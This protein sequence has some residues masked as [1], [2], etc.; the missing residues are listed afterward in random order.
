MVLKNVDIELR[1]N[2]LIIEKKTGDL[3]SGKRAVE[4]VDLTDSATHGLR[5]ALNNMEARHG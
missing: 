2:T 4:M 3:F 5:R 1:G